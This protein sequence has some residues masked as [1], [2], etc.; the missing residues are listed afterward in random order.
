[1]QILPVLDL[2]SG[3]I[4][5]A[6]AGKRKEYRPI[7]STMVDSTEPFEVARALRNRFGLTEL[8]LADLDSIQTGQPNLEM[9]RALQDDGCRLWLDAGL[10]HG[11]DPAVPALIRLQIARIIVGLETIEGPAELLRIVQAAGSEAVVFSLDLRDS[12]PLLRSD[13]WGGEPWEIARSVVEMGVRRLIVLDLARVGVGAGVG[14]EALCR[15]IKQEF[16]RV[17]VA[18]GG[19]VRGIE[20]L[21]QLRAIGV[22]YAL[23]ASAL[24]DGRLSRADLAAI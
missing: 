6:V 24:H 4:V 13:S 20:D 17:E 10:R 18:T 9:Y 7:L 5:R 22:D 12:R 8:Y 3:Q 21:N 1:M 23:V 11:D 14:T 16:P 2:L 19:G 15:R